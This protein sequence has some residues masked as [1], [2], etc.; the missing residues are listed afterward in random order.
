MTRCVQK[1]DLLAIGERYTESTNVLCD[2]T[3][4]ASCNACRTHVIQDCGL[5]VINV[6]H[7]G[8]NRRSGR[9]FRILLLCRR[10]SGVKI[11]IL[12]F[13]PERGLEVVLLRDEARMLGVED[14][15]C[16]HI[17]KPKLFQLGD[18]VFN[19]QSQHAR[20]VCHTDIL[21]QNNGRR[22][23]LFHSSCLLCFLAET[24][25]LF[26]TNKVVLHFVLFVKPRYTPS[27]SGWASAALRLFVTIADL[28]WLDFESPPPSLFVSVAA[29]AVRLLFDLVALRCHFQLRPPLAHPVVCSICQ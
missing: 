17:L 4:L 21:R 24:L 2:A 11:A 19:P 13:A 8:D 23:G 12:V 18:E 14:L 26:L 9:Q 28:S 15:S 27:V 22:F 7:D 29:S 16:L 25:L 5:A 3:K 6:T 1:R 10:R 20:Q